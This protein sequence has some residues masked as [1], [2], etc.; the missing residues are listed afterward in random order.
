MTGWS[1][2]GVHF[3]TPESG[4]K[5]ITVI[6]GDHRDDGGDIDRDDLEMMR[7]MAMVF[8]IKKL[9]VTQSEKVCVI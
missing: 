9:S 7:R 5:V 1:D 8:M 6:I 3:Y 2:G 4:F